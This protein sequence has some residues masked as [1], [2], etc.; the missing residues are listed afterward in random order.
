MDRIGRI[1]DMER[2]YDEAAAAVA[3][4]ENAIDGFEA[5]LPALKGL[6]DYQES[7]RWLKDFEADEKGALPEGMKR[8]GIVGRRAL[9]S[10]AESGRAL[11]KARDPNKQSGRSRDIIQKHTKRTPGSSVLF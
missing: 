5:A 9:R 3:A 1:Q 10:A 4:L 7:G 8:G 6:S 11:R 2:R